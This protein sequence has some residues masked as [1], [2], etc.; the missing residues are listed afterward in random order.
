MAFTFL[1]AM[2][3]SV[4]NSLVESK[5]ITKA[6]NILDIARNS[7]KKIILPTDVVCSNNI[8][9]SESG[10]AVSVRDMPDDMMG[11][12]IG[13]KTI[14]KYLEALSSAKT[15]LWNGPMG[16]FENKFFENGTRSIAEK[17]VE[18]ALYDSTVIAGGGDTASALRHFKLA[19]KITHVSTGGGASL[20]LMSG[21]QLKA[22]NKLEI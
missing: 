18:I 4:G 16:V 22:I 20:A 12:D 11:L 17:L 5:M 2:G 6:K 10:S 8:S 15:I 3:Y 21:N 19:E 1:K 14:E 7:G 9:V 13:P